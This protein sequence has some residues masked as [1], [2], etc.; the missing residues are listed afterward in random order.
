MGFDVRSIHPLF[1]KMTRMVKIGLVGIEIAEWIARLSRGQNAFRI[2]II[3][4]IQRNAHGRA[5]EHFIIHFFIS[6][7][8]LFFAAG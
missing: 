3:C 5:G 8:A 4:E 7:G 2:T 6:N 1:P